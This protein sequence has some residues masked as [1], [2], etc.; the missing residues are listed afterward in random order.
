[1]FYGQYK[2]TIDEKSRLS[3]PA[4]FRALLVGDGNDKFYLTRGLE[5][6]I[7]LCTTKKWLALEE[8][9]TRHSLTNPAA[10]DFKRAFYSGAGEIT[11][12]KQGRIAIPQNLLEYAEIKRDVVIVGVSDAIE[13]WDT[14]KWSK[15]I[16]TL[17]DNFGDAAKKLE[18]SEK[19]K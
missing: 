17:L 12:D 15:S 3:I 16:S 11:F 5:K 18:E 2:H 19:E 14:E 10:R 13:I 7:L 1:M 6:H 9:F 8:I 4:K